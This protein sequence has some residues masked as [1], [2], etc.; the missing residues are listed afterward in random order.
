MR[1]NKLLSLTLPGTKQQHHVATFKSRNLKNKLEIIVA[2]LLKKHI[3]LAC[4]L[5]FTVYR[6][7]ATSKAGF[8]EVIKVLLLLQ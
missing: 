3:K 2:C 4:C 5:S 1:L 6:Q 7:A 8:V